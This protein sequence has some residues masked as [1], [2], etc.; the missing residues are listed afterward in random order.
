MAVPS[1]EGAT[2]RKTLLIG[3]AMAA[4]IGLA[5]CSSGS[6]KA[7]INE[8]VSSL[9]A[10]S[11]LQVHLTASAAGPGSAQAE[12]I[13]KQLSLELR[14]SNPS[15]GPIS[16]SA[17]STNSEIIATLAGKTFLDFRTVD[18]NVY[19][20]ANVAALAGVPGIK[21]TPAQI[22]EVQLILGGRWFELQ[23][24]LLNSVLSKTH[25][26]QAKGA[27]EQAFEAKLVDAIAN[28]IDTTRYTSLGNGS[29]SETG[30]LE[31]IIQAVA[32]T[33]QS[34]THTFS[35]PSSV[36]GT[37]TVSITTSGSNATG[38]TVSIS[39]PNG[40][41]GTA[42]GTLTVTVAHDN[43]SIVAPTGATVITPTLLQ[44]L[45][46]LAGKG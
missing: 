35:V 28:V 11:T 31:S 41:K 7:T 14:Y 13:L 5:A 33:I 22:A 10:H 16:K 30:T 25:A 6:T 36:R 18:S 17:A 27:A 46:S 8:Y 19:V 43:I 9:G 2:L 24:S 12:R 45:R 32:P 40:A 38:A 3:G 23:R 42:T 15:G 1:R 4:S 37:Y 39:A 34:V 44:Q 20:N 21:V 29:Y 26:Q